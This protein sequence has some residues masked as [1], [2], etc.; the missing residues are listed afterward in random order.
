MSH[1]NTVMDRLAGLLGDGGGDARADGLIREAL[2]SLVPDEAPSDMDVAAFHD[3]AL[4]EDDAARVRLALLRDPERLE[5]YLAFADAMQ[6]LDSLEA[7][8]DLKPANEPLLRRLAPVLGALAALLLLGLTLLWGGGGALEAPEVELLRERSGPVLR[9]GAAQLSPDEGLRIA[10]SVAD[11]AWWAVVVARDSRTGVE[12][13][14]AS[15]SRKGAES[16]RHEDGRVLHEESLNGTVGERAYYVLVSRDPIEGLDDVVATLQREL[17]SGQHARTEFASDTRTLL[18][19][20]AQTHG[21]RV[22][23]TVHVAVRGL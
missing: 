12:L 14:V 16:T 7:P 6:A 5:D 11:S 10:A 18:G 2:L 17:R 3:G 8:V 13:G 15:E 23:K 21:W 19:E 4:D 20:Q 22:S 1:E 9:S